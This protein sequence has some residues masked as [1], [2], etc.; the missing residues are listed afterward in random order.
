MNGLLFATMRAGAS[1]AVVAATLAAAPAGADPVADF[2]RGKLVTVY[3]GYSVGGGYDLYARTLARHMG[4][5]IP[6]NPKFVVKNRPGAGSLVLANEIY[7]THP[8]DGTAFGT[9]GRGIVMEPMFGNK[10]ARFDATK[11]TWL[12]SMNN[13]VSL[14]VSW[15]T[16]DIKT[17][18]DMFRKK[19]IVGGTG[20]GSD[21][22]AF[23]LVFNNVLG[24]RMK[25]VTG[26]PG[27]N[28]INF[29]ME[30][31]EVH[32]RCAWSWSSIKTTRANWLRDKKINLLL[33]MSTSKHPELPNVPF[34]MDFAKIDRERQILSI[35]YARQVWGRPFVAPP[36][37]PAD[38]AK[39]LQK[40]FMDTMADPVFLA[41]AKKIKLDL[42]PESGPEVHKLIAEL[43]ATPKEMLAAAAAATVNRA[44]TE[45]DKAVI[46]IE[47]LS[48][49]IIGI[50]R[51]GRS[52]TIGQ[53]GKKRKVRVSGRRTQILV[54]GAK[55]KRKALKLGMAC[56]L[57]YQGSAAKKIDCK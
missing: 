28:D 25:L 23:P 29:A 43:A 5:N 20:Q 26:Y 10:K 19:F 8:K 7:N 21:T 13:E 14:C 54:A 37:L 51:G 55:K 18:D 9:V 56:T 36:G 52:V 45:I 41:E 49:T 57:T 1:V 46:P 31:G 27:G 35:I 3:V 17:V 38:R 39:A 42:A 16:T 44:K 24:A 2:Y 12:G 4:R 15:H 30:R 48:G 53:G 32:G 40:A 22:D 47:T 6:G 33:Q 50:K 34:V 11:Y